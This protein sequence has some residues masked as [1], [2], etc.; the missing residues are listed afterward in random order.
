VL[1]VVRDYTRAYERMDV[2][3]AKA[4]RPSL[5]D[6][7]L[8][9]AFEQLNAQQFR[10]PNCGVSIRGQDANARCQGDATYHPK[11]GSRVHFTERVWTFN[12]SR[13]DAGWQIVD[14][15]FQ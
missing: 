3:A 4:L 15:K 9:L 5:D 8:R 12:L 1:Q 14:A 10:F 13:G 7:A 6:R 11:V 2:R